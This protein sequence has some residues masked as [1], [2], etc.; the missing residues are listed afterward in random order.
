MTGE[1]EKTPTFSIVVPCYNETEC[2]QELYKRVSTTLDGLEGTWEL[3]L[4]DDGS[5]DGTIEMIEGLAAEDPRVRPVIL[6]RNFGH[7]IAVTAGLDHTRGAAV[8][9]MDADLQDPPE[10]IPEMAAR[11]REGFKIVA[12]T[13]RPNKDEAMWRRVVNPIFYRVLQRIVD[14]PLAI[15]SGDFRLMDRE[16][17]DIINSMPERHRFLRGMAAWTGFRQTEVAYDRP[18]RFA[19]ESKYPLRKMIGLA[20]TGITSFSYYPLKLMT[21]LGLAIAVVTGITLPVV[22]IL[23]LAGVAGLY[24]QTTVF[25]AVMFF[26]GLQ[27]LS[28]GILGDYLGR[29]YDEVKARPLYLVSSRSAPGASFAARGGARREAVEQDGVPDLGER[30]TILN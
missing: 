6:V 27:I 2:L 20:M 18:V 9:V 3:V 12:G 13:R 21:M 26:G 28:I 17:V 25:L 16:V 14:F 15:D 30:S 29:V 10:L 7:Q 19:G 5:T 11:W 24:G 4:V 23:R 22:I 8:I 1:P